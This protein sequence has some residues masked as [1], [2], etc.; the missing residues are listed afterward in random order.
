MT[1][2]KVTSVMHIMDDLLDFLLA[3]DSDEVL[4]HTW[5]RLKKKVRSLPSISD[6]VY[7]EVLDIHLD[8]KGSVGSDRRNSVFQGVQVIFTSLQAE[9]GVEFEHLKYKLCMVG[10]ELLSELSN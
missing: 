6:E 8:V 4:L 5:R 3:G 2:K 10:L 9:V 1:N 7:S